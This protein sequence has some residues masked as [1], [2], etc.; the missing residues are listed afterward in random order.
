ML[1]AGYDC[2]DTLSQRWDVL[3]EIAARVGNCLYVETWWLATLANVD[4]ALR[5]YGPA[6]RTGAVGKYLPPRLRIARR[7]CMQVSVVAQI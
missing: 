7:V 2:E 6:R 1:R 5:S 3:P 4:N